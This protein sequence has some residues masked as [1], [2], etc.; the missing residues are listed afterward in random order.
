MTTFAIGVACLIVLAGWMLRPAWRSLHGT[1]V[2][3]TAAQPTQLA[4]L[5]EQLAALDR[6]HAA[7]ELDAQQHRRARN[8]LQWRVLDEAAAHDAV[9]GSTRSPKALLCVALAVPLFSIALYAAIGNPAAL[10]TPPSLSAALAPQ[11]EQSTPDPE[12]SPEVMQA[13]LASLAQ[14]LEKPSTDPA[15]DLQGWTML[16]RSYAALQRFPEADSAYAR[17][18]AL[19]PKDAQLLADRADVLAMIQ[20]QRTGGEPDRLIAEALRIDPKNPKAL[21]LAG[22]AAFEKKDFEAAR[23]YWQKARALASDDSEFAA[24][25]ERSLIAAR[26]AGGLAATATP[27]ATT[28]TTTAPLSDLAAPARITGRVSLAPALS[29]KAAPSDTVFIFA[30]AAE[31]PRMP[32]AIIRRTVADLPFAFTLDDSLAMSAATKLSGASRVIVG[33]RVSRSGNAMPQTGDLRGE[34]A[35]M[36][37]HADDLQLVIDGVQP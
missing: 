19:A 14:R 18:I 13:M 32:L 8:E 11:G 5:R 30:R 7:G 36:R 6:E 23:N 17:A 31:G 2:A 20:G 26:E 37:T 24:G 4:I 25:L 1:A 10:S 21:A 27:V 29:S 34:S 16:A 9:I 22:S 28:A 3:I 15:N 35:A 12:V 33:A